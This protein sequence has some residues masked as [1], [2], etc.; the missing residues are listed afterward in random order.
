MVETETVEMVREEEGFIQSVVEHIFTMDLPVISLRIKGGRVHVVLGDS[1]EAVPLVELSV[2]K[3]EIVIRGKGQYAK[4]KHI[5]I[6]HKDFTYVTLLNSLKEILPLPVI[7]SMRF[8]GGVLANVLFLY[9]K[10]APVEVS[11]KKQLEEYNWKLELKINN[12][13]RTLYLVERGMLHKYDITRWRGDRC[14]LLPSY[15]VNRLALK[16]RRM[17]ES[18]YMDSRKLLLPLNYDNNLLTFLFD[19]ETFHEMSQIMW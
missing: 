5:K 14:I 19:E 8:K 10:D 18:G 1:T 13:R 7:D 3:T 15:T 4:N 16:R 12:K 17:E 6:K 2:N 11:L 9:R